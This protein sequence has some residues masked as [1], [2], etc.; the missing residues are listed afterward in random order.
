MGSL[1]R[2]GGIVG[3]CASVDLGAAAKKLE[4]GVGRFGVVE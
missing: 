4:R 2:S 3:R 1:A